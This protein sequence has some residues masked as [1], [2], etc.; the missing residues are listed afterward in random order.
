MNW[1]NAGA[2]K[3]QCQALKGMA[4]ALGGMAIALSERV[5]CCAVPSSCVRAAILK[6]KVVSLANVKVIEGTEEMD[7]S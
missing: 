5:P 2:C 4:P 6:Q 1:M 3:G 7:T